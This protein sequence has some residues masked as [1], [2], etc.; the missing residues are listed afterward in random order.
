MSYELQTLTH[1]NLGNSND[2]IF[3]ESVGNHILH[4]RGVVDGTVSGTVDI[5]NC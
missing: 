1:H 5:L 3:V 2:F 4:G